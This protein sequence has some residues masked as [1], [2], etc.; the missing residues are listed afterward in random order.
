MPLL[1]QECR[2]QS[3]TTKKSCDAEK[4]GAAQTC[5]PLTLRSPCLDREAASQGTLHRG[6]QRCVR[7]PTLRDGASGDGGRALHK[8]IDPRGAGLSKCTTAAL[9]FETLTILIMFAFFPYNYPTFF[10]LSI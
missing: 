7:A 2:P 4:A 1:Q 6:G 5:L 8:D 9:F 3:P 10:S